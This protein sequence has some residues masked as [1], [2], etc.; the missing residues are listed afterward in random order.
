[1]S[2][3]TVN[4]AISLIQKLYTSRINQAD[5]IATQKQL[6]AIQRGPN[7][8]DLVL[9]L[10]QHSDP[11]CRFFGALT[12]SVRI[13]I[14]WLDQNRILDIASL[15]AASIKRPDVPVVTIKLADA[16][17][18]LIAKYPDVIPNPLFCLLWSIGDEKSHFSTEDCEIANEN[19]QNPS[20]ISAMLTGL[21]PESLHLF[22]FICKVFAEDLDNNAPSAEFTEM[23][24]NSCTVMEQLLATP[25]TSPMDW[26]GL[27]QAWAIL[28]R[29]HL[30]DS[31]ILRLR[32]FIPT[33]L[34]YLK[35]DKAF[36][37]VASSLSDLID[38]VPT[39]FNNDLIASTI[40]TC[41]PLVDAILKEAEYESDV[42]TAWIELLLS[43]TSYSM[44][45]TLMMPFFQ[46]VL[47]ALFK[48]TATS[49]IENEYKVLSQTVEFWN[50]FCDTTDELLQEGSPHAP[51]CKSIIQRSIA[52]LTPRAIIPSIDAFNS[53]NSDEKDQ[54]NGFRRELCDYLEFTLTPLGDETLSYFTQMAANS[55]ADQTPTRLEAYIC[56]I[57]G[58]SY[59]L[60][61]KS[62]E[63]AQLLSVFW[64]DSFISKM[65]ASRAVP[66]IAN[67][68][69][70]LISNYEQYIALSA[71]YEFIQKLMSVLFSFLTEK[72][73]ALPASKAI[74]SL[75]LA[76]RNRLHK[77]LPSLMSVIS[78]DI[79]STLDALVRE[80]IVS[81]LTTIVNAEPN[82]PTR[83]AGFLQILNLI[84]L[85]TQNLSR[86]NWNDAENALIMLDAFCSAVNDDSDE[87]NETE[88]GI[89]VDD[90]QAF[91]GKVYSYEDKIAIKAKILAITRDIV[92]DRCG[93]CNDP[94]VVEHA[95]SIIKAGLYDTSVEDSLLSITPLEAISFIEVGTSTNFS[96]TGY[97]Y[98]RLAIAVLGNL[99]TTGEPEN[100]PIIQQLFSTVTERT[101]STDASNPDNIFTIIDFFRAI[102][103]N[104][105]NVFF[106]SIYVG[107]IANFI[108]FYIGYPEL[109]VKKS[110]LMFWQALLTNK[111]SVKEGLFAPFIESI[112][113][114]LCLSVVKLILGQALRS[115]LVRVSELYKRLIFKFPIQM[116]Q[117][118]PQAVD[119]LQ[120]RNISQQ[121]IDQFITKSLVLRGGAKTTEIVKDIWLQARGQT[122]DY[123]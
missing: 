86:I 114:S 54:F 83:V 41:L 58:I 92:F 12:V 73:L 49:P 30:T 115:E 53:W 47:E 100:S 108:I 77:M 101:A 80:R 69:V 95:T 119:E 15:I 34:N 105:P 4:E 1:M 110:A 107:D 26:I 97:L 29:T 93:P 121:A 6:Q 91:H 51:F 71:D 52:T 9:V 117:W 16:F 89:N 39:L 87:A 112:G 78:N 79:F 44:E 104:Y 103:L 37:T 28:I 48:V 45:T 61:A 10:L 70:R 85:H 42:L 122:S 18:T 20:A 75:C 21:A 94:T 23:L 40:S 19:A 123:I 96:E 67:T 68:F 38:Q 88:N 25:V 102:I 98:I 56:F 72:L 36:K 43:A 109:F 3:G 62:A 99:K 27:L 17:S 113:Y 64:N 11:N 2:D 31:S 65:D 116:K 60:P 50:N 7:G 118:L 35:D 120:P 24:N 66:F 76:Y 106:E 63:V 59:S 84:Q 13:N 32:E 5:V 90:D 111:D 55:L 74:Q 57:N 22:F 81:G 8:W 46:D 14:E 82:I 33:A